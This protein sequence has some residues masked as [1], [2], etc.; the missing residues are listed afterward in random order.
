MD[1]IT[2]KRYL[3]KYIGALEDEEES[4]EFLKEQE[5]RFAQA[6]LQKTTPWCKGEEG[7]VVRCSSDKT[8]VRFQNK[9]ILWSKESVINANKSIQTKA[10]FSSI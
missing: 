1:A 9:G 3:Q 7:Q 4:I 2:V 8:K 5:E 10:G 6:L